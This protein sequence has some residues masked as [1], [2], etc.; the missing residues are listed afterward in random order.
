MYW[1]WCIPELFVTIMKG[2]HLRL[3]LMWMKIGNYFVTGPLLF[4]KHSPCFCNGIQVS[5]ECESLERM[6]GKGHGGEDVPDGKTAEKLT[7][8]KAENI[9]LQKSLQSVHQC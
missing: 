8:L 4:A 5:G 9:A 1:V 7:H 2:A 3:C 6:A